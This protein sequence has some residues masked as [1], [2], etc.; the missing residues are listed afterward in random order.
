MPIKQGRSAKK[1]AGEAKKGKARQYRPNG[2]RELLSQL[3]AAAKGLDEEGLEFI[4][5]QAHVLLYNMQVDKL[6]E[7]LRKAKSAVQGVRKKT[8]PETPDFPGPGPGE[9]EIVEKHGSGNFFIVVNN[10]HIL[11][12]REEMRSLVKLC[13]AAADGKEASVRLFNW[14]NRNRKDLLI[15]GGIV[16]GTHPALESI[17]RIIVSRYRVRDGG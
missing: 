5:N 4:L 10:Y 9:V 13:H 3:G 17:W 2:K 11:F 16:S 7:R 12:T 14:F 1:K 15:D 6:N 8:G